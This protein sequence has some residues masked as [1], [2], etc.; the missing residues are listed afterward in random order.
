MNLIQGGLSEPPPLK[1]KAGLVIIMG[2]ALVV[3]V[4]PHDGSTSEWVL[5]KGTIESNESAQEA[6]IREALEETGAVVAPELD[7]LTKTSRTYQVIISA[8]ESGEETEEVT[9]FAGRGVA[10]K[11]ESITDV[12]FDEIGGPRQ[13]GIFPALV[14]V[15]KLTYEEH[16]KVLVQALSGEILT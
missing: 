1:K 16:R 5:P 7:L 10:L 15:A 6:A 9:W 8:D 12:V 11:T 3:L 2:K 13:I 14:A 4:R